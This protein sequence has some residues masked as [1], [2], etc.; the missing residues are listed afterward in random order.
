MKASQNI[1][2]CCGSL[3]KSD[4]QLGLKELLHFA[5][6]IGVPD[7]LEGA[8]SLFGALN[9]TLS[10]FGAAFCKH[11][12]GYFT[13]AFVSTSLIRLCW[14][15]GNGAWRHIPAV[16]QIPSTVIGSYSSGHTVALSGAEPLTNLGLLHTGVADAEIGPDG[17]PDT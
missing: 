16:S 15:G 17:V 3:G 2:Q 1:T 10:L 4:E 12:C 7:G 8:N 13:A 9:Q 11:P 6:Q 5:T 14:F